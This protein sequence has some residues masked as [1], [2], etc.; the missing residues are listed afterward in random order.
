[1][2]IPVEYKLA[3]LY[4]S[5]VIG[6][7]SLY[8]GKWRKVLKSRRDFDLDRTMPIMS[9][10][11]SYTTMY[12]NFTHTRTHARTHAHTNTHTHTL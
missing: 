9:E 10:I 4:Q 8:C 2:N 11:F 5:G 6:P 1:M 3:R 12:S 7:Y